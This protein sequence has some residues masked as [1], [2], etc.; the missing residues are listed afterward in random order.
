MKLKKFV[1]LY[2]RS[3]VASYIYNFLISL[4]F[5]DSKR[6]LFPLDASKKS[7]LF[8]FTS[9]PPSTSLTFSSSI[10]RPNTRSSSLF[11]SSLTSAGGSR[12][13]AFRVSSSMIQSPL[14][15]PKKVGIRAMDSDDDDE[16]IVIQPPPQQ[17]SPKE[18]EA[19]RLRSAENEAKSKFAH[20]QLVIVDGKAAK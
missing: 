8:T 9:L 19:E 20:N 13:S 17:L 16:E 4:P 15:D 6:C 3:P 18:L 11:P 7:T 1:V 5:S 12:R 10:G 14:P 2:T